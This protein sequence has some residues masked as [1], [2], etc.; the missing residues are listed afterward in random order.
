MF[1]CKYIE[2]IMMGVGGRGQSME[3][4][5]IHGYM[6]RSSLCHVG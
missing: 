3:S 6:P 4:L 1:L 5:S 2:K